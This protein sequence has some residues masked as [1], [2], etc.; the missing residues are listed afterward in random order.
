MGFLRE[1]LGWS[2]GHQA[3]LPTKW[4]FP[5]PVPQMEVMQVAV[6]RQQEGGDLLP[7]LSPSQWWTRARHLRWALLAWLC[8]E[9]LVCILRNGDGLEASPAPDTYGLLLRVGLGRPW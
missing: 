3:S 4:A 5:V 1:S 2:Q 8:L 9:Q 6:L 7:I